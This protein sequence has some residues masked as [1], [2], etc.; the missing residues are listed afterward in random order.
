ML[1][2]II[3]VSDIDITDLK[4]KGELETDFKRMESLNLENAPNNA[5][6][7]KVKVS[8]SIRTYMPGL[9]RFRFEIQ[10]GNFINGEFKPVG[11]ILFYQTET[12][13]MI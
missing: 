4:I 3:D 12:L 7:Y 8:P 2:R 11:E 5:E 9:H 6:A 10:Y 1:K 13:P